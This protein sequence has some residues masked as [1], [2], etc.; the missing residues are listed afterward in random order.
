MVEK[1]IRTP[2]AATAKALHKGTSPC[3]WGVKE[4]SFL[5]SFRE[6]LVIFLDEIFTFALH[7]PFFVFDYL[8]SPHG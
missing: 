1:A 8:T 6:N 5:V 7:F 3:D 4:G 2:T